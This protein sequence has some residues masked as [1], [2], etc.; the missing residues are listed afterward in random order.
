M[1]QLA[2]LGVL[3]FV[4]IGTAWLEIFLRT[5]VY[6]RWKRLLLSLAPVLVVFVGWD[7]YAITNGHWDFDEARTTGVVF[8]VVPL[9]EVLF[10]IVIP[11]AAILTLEAVRS[12]KG[13]SVG[14]DA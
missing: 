13:W 10:F 5:R 9:D 2:Y 6:R 12:V 3:A 1:S 8:G 7:V 11:I 4:L 14:D